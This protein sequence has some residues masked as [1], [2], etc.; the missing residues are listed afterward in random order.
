[1]IT[2]RARVI[3]D[4]DYCGDPDGLVQLV[5]Q[6]LSP[7]AELR[8]VIGSHLAADDPFM[9]APD[10]A[11]QSYQRVTEVLSIMERTVPAYQG[12]NVG[13]A[14]RRTPQPS[15]GAEAI[16]AEAMR[17]DTDLP[18]Y[19]TF[20]GGLT[21][22]ASAY[23]MEPRIADRLTAIWIGGPEHPDLAPPPPDTPGREYNLNID[24]LAAQ[25]VFN[26][27]PIPL[28]QVPRNAYRQALVTMAEL[29]VHLRPAGKIGAHLY[30]SI[31]RVFELASGAGLNLGETYILGDSPLVLL[32]TLQSCFHPDPSSSRYVQRPTPRID[33]DGN[34]QPREDGR[35]IR[36]YTDLDIRV[37]VQDFYAKL[38][39]ARSA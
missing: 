11:A 5:H 33:D 9:P 30:D 13:L 1:M 19:V 38:A 18:L 34:Y 29:E 36:V 10:T 4:N 35:P 15:A 28:W 22:L 32:S 27:S 23:L 17:T 20:G 8:G 31:C 37:M 2:P 39:L 14:D 26:E 6:L 21:E 7:S 3:T 24:P 16:V 12:S 25:V